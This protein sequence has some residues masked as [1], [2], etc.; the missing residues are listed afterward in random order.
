[1]SARRVLPA[2]ASFLVGVAF[3][4]GSLNID[5]ELAQRIGG[6]IGPVRYPLILAI[7]AMVLALLILLEPSA[8]EVLGVPDEAAAATVPGEAAA[9]MRPGGMALRFVALFAA[10]L[11]FLVLFRPLGYALTA[12]GLIFAIMLLNGLR[13]VFLGL[14][15]SVAFVA[16]CYL[17]FTRILLVRLPETPFLGGLF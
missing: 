6:V 3:L 11:A 12:T 16:L 7:A 1:M 15:V 5:A 14:A 8:P 17:A 10:I 9:A 4:V 13:N 2:L